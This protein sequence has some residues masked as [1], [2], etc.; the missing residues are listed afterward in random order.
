MK[1]SPV[2]QGFLSQYPN[3]KITTSLIAQGTIVTQIE[4]IKKDCEDFQVGSYYKSVLTDSDSGTKLTVWMNAENY[5]VACIVQEKSGVNTPV[6]LTPL[7]TT[8]ISLTNYKGSCTLGYGTPFIV[9]LGPQYTNPDSMLFLDDACNE[10]VYKEQ[11]KI[12][13]ASN[14][15]PVMWDELVLKPD[16]NLLWEGR[17]FESKV[18]G[19]TEVNSSSCLYHGCDGSTC[20]LKEGCGGWVPTTTTTISNQTN[21]TTS[22]TTTSITPLPIDLTIKILNQ[23]TSFYN[24]NN[25]ILI[26]AKITNN[27]TVDA[28]YVA[29]GATFSPPDGSASAAC[30]F[31]TSIGAIPKED[32][33]QNYSANSF[34]ILLCVVPVKGTYDTEAV[35]DKY[36]AVAETNEQNNVD[37]V[38]LTFS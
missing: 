23:S 15:V 5:Q 27:G 14:S 25:Y 32:I 24:G 29:S 2:V 4:E 38:R 7:A 10:H 28:N 17:C 3:A 33:R 21:Q 20:L 26:Y 36:N 37:K 19:Q 22:S 12:Y 16:G 35:V 31:H 11:M 30:G 6:S 8:T 18:K 13:C 9:D 34:K 1:A